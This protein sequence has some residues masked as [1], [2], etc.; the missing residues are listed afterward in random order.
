MILYLSNKMFINVQC[1]ILSKITNTKVQHLKIVQKWI[2]TLI[3]NRLAALSSVARCCTFQNLVLIFRQL[4][5]G[6]VAHQCNGSVAHQCNGRRLQLIDNQYPFLEIATP[7]NTYKSHNT[8]IIK[9]IQENMTILS[10]ALLY[11]NI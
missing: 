11:N 9:Y 5:R 10:V 8:L 2:N 1:A 7:C 3:V 4:S 6:S